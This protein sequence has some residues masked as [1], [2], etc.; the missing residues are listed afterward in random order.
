MNRL[1][2]SWRARDSFGSASAVNFLVLTGQVAARSVAVVFLVILG[3]TAQGAVGVAQ[4]ISLLG[5]NALGLG[6]QTGLVKT[7]AVRDT[8]A[9]ASA[10]M[11]TT[12]AVS[13]LVTVAGAAVIAL[14]ATPSLQVTVG[15]I[16]LPAQVMSLLT[17][18]FALGT[19][20][21]SGFAAITLAPFVLFAAALFGLAVLGHLTQDGALIAFAAAFGFAGL[22]SSAAAARWSRPAI[23]RT[24]TR[25]PS[26]HLA[27]RLL[28]GALAQLVNYRFDQVVIAAVLSTRQ[29]GLY[30]LAVSASEVGA[31]PG[32]GMANI[33]LRRTSHDQGYRQARS[34]PRLA[35]I[36][37]LL[38]LPFIP[39]VVLLIAL[40]LPEYHDSIAPFM[41]LAVGA[42]AVGSGRV[43]AAWL[44]ARGYAW[45][46]SRAAFVALIVSICGNLAL[47][48]LFG[49][50]GAS[51][52]STAAYSAAAV[53]LLR[54][55]QLEVRTPP[56]T[57]N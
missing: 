7:A 33:L 15:L 40:A 26:F 49:I 35:A 41:V 54:R 48:P 36:A 29:L 42:G 39:P 10:A 8:R 31:L 9:D 34:V 1:S 55:V 47:I 37:Y 28:P 19:D 14:V 2:A 6:L 23:S 11:W 32:T 16:A 18:A 43:L 56:A 53:V 44:T 38:A 45:E 20:R 13:V 57:A 51:I 25:S 22:A 46:G 27:S 24:L 30:G 5:S 4:L 17:A 3:P 21:R 52:A 50:V 12:I